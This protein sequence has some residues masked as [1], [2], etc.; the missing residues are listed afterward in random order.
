M[1]EWQKIKTLET[2]QF[3][4]YY[5]V[6][7]DQVLTPAG[8]SGEYSVIRMHPHVVIIPVDN[9]RQIYMVRQHRYP[10]DKVTLELPIG[11]TDGQELLVAAQRELEEETGFAAKEWDY[12]GRFNEGSGIGEIYG[13][14]FIAKQLS[15]IA[16]PRLDD[17]DRDLIEI[18]K[19]TLADIRKMIISEEI[20]NAS[21]ICA[22]TKAMLAAKLK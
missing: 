18:S 5:R 3:G 7:K 12:L 19:H 16:N 10:L 4:K 13:H 17:L 2:S 20:E 15:K 21:T 14:A 1:K 11:S 6:E 9:D 8:E 22:F